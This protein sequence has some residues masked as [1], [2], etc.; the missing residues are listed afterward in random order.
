[1]PG[2]SARRGAFGEKEG[3][4][5]LCPSPWAM[6]PTRLSSASAVSLGRR[7]LQGRERR[8]SL[9][10]RERGLWGGQ[11]AVVSAGGGGEW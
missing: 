2:D 4:S 1:M 9:P 11:G 7:G 8:A 6:R 10:R 3:C 5:E